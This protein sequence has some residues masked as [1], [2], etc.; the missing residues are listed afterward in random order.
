MIDSAVF[1]ACKAVNLV[2]LIGNTTRL[3]KVAANEWAGPCPRCGGKDR[4]RVSNR[5]WFCRQCQG[6]PGSGGHWHDAI[7]YEMWLHGVRLT[8]AIE[9]LTGNR[10]IDRVELERIAAERQRRE[11]D[12]E[13][14]ERLTAEEA[15]RRL[16]D[17]AEWKSYNAH[18]QAVEQWARRG[19]RPEWVEYYGLGYCPDRE[20]FIDGQP[21][22]SDSLTIP[23]F[24]AVE[25]EEAITYKVV[26]LKH[27]LL[28]SDAPG[29][30]YRH[31]IAGCGNNLFYADILQRE[32]F[33]DLLIVEGEIKTIITWQ[34]CWLGDDCMAPRLTVVGVPGKNWKPGW[35]EKFR[36]AD[37][38]FV[39]LD[40]DA[41]RES[42]KLAAD[43]GENARA[44]KLPGK[45]D[46]LILIGALDVFKLF[47]LLE[48]A[49][50]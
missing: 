39:N 5:G 7:D 20:F 15:I 23:Y 26:D 50:R 19:V 11:A 35:V 48:A 14:R 10:Q 38:I 29:G 1:E 36:K 46:D 28:K 42:A 2:D 47:D 16:T 13:E 4:L 45:I 41:N 21:F 8:E 25:G 37:R 32:I 33:G 24:R 3:Q 27:R 9:R 12:Q 31:H 40:P 22:N 34:V 44:F 30:K 6:E 17:G 43:I 49:W 18:S